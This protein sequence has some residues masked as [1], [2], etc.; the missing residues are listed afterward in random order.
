MRAG[1]NLVRDESALVQGLPHAV[2]VLPQPGMIEIGVE[3]QVD[4]PGQEQ[5]VE[6][7]HD[8]QKVVVGQLFADQ[9]QVD[10]RA[11][12]ERAHGAG[13][14]KNSLFDIG[15]QGQYR[16]DFEYGLFGQSETHQE[17]SLFILATLGRRR[18]LK[19]RTTCQQV[20]LFF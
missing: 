4:E 9:G 7:G 14:V 1:A 8:A 11:G 3:G 13:T 20:A 2:D 15:I 19:V 10:V 5:V 6:V 17:G 12:L 18:F 16:L